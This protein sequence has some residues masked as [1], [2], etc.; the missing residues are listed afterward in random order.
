MNA[1]GVH[2]DQRNHEH[3]Y[4]CFTASFEEPIIR[5]DSDHYAGARFVRY[6]LIRYYPIDK[7]ATVVISEESRQ[8]D[9]RKLKGSVPGIIKIDSRHAPVLSSNFLKDRHLCQRWNPKGSSRTQSLLASNV[10]EPTDFTSVPRNGRAIDFVYRMAFFENPM[11]DLGGKHFTLHD[12]STI[13][14]HR[15]DASSLELSDAVLSAALLSFTDRD[16]Y[17][18]GGRPVELGK[19]GYPI[20]WMRTN[21]QQENGKV[22]LK[23]FRL[24]FVRAAL[25]ITS[26]RQEARFQSLIKCVKAGSAKKAT[27]A[28]ND[29]Q[30]KP[31][32]RLLEYSSHASREKQSL[33]LRDL[34]LG[35]NHID[36]D[37]LRRNG[38]YNPRFPTKIN[39]LEIEVEDVV[40]SD[41]IRDV[42]VPEKGI[43]YYKIRCTAVV[44]FVGDGNDMENDLG[45]AFNGRIGRLFKEEWIVYRSYKEFQVLH[46]HLKTQVSSSESSGTAGSRLVGVASAALS[47]GGS[48]GRNRNRNILIPS[49]AQATKI[50][51]LGLTHKSLLKRKEFLKS[52]LDYLSSPGHP[53][54]RCTELL[55]FVGAFYPFPPDV[56]VGASVSGVQDPLGRSLMRRTVVEEEVLQTNKISAGPDR[57]RTLSFEEPNE[58]GDDFN[59]EQ[60]ALRSPAKDGDMIPSVRAKIDRV[61]LATVRNRLFDLLRYLFGFENASFVRNRMLAALKTASFAVTSRTEFRRMLYK[62]HTERISADAIG[63]LLDYVLNMLWP[64]GIFFTPAPPLTEEE[65]EEAVVNSKE[66]LHGSFP[67]ALRAILGQEL[68]KDGIDI[69]HEMLQN[70]LVLRSMTHHLLAAV[71][72]EAFPELS[73]I[74]ADAPSLDLD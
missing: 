21:P 17:S 70:R 64:D 68:T 10:M 72:N 5:P 32:T 47:S 50:G 34:K 26:A 28:L 71:W 63:G 62:I 37:Q 6:C 61:P 24:S 1:V 56:S 8:L 44:E 38:L 59:D 25:L 48:H 46:K 66:A 18:T 54:S 65:K 39:E 31:V 11:V 49:L 73:D 12:S 29:A 33:V 67:E 4:R 2:R 35:V 23:P 13:G 53:L 14:T 58:D 7:T 19:D 27:R 69:F 42:Y 52:Y 57:E 45:Y 51:A 20:V 55:L 74:L 3:S 36:V 9:Q 60:E 41:E 30:L 22:E 15:A 40:S 16:A 43:Y